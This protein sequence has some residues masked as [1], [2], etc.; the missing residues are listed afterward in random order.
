M[1]G[2]QPGDPDKAARAMIE[3]VFSSEPPELLLLGEDAV[4]AFRAVLDAQRA[5]IDAWE[6]VSRGT[7]FDA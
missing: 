6:S 4:E 7:G 5:D 2:T 3:A 1:H